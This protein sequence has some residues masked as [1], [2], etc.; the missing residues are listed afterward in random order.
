MLQRLVLTQFQW[1]E[2]RRQ[3]TADVPLESCGLLAGSR[4]IAQRVV[5]V[6]N[7]LHS[8]TR[9]RFTPE[10]Q[11]AAFEQ[12]ENSGMEILAIYHSHPKGPPHPSP[13]D[14]AE[15][16]YPVVYIIWSPENDVWQARGFWIENGSYKVVPL[17]IVV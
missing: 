2:M 13:T 1:E 14:I 16:S 5:S 12:I 15:A 3:V 6:P 11:L 7:A 4:D 9:Y 10:A 8:A 17:E